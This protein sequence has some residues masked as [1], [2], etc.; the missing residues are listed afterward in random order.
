MELKIKIVNVVKKYYCISKVKV[1]NF[2]SLG[3][4]S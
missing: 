4:D 1:I 2:L 3:F